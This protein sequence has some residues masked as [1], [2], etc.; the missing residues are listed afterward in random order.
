[1]IRVTLGPANLNN[2]NTFSFALV[3]GVH[4]VQKH[5]YLEETE[6]PIEEPAAAKGHGA[7]VDSEHPAHEHFVE[8]QHER[9]DGVGYGE[10]DEHDAHGHGAER[11]VEHHEDRQAV[12][13]ER[14]AWE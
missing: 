13:C 3:S 11:L 1:M 14:D 2:K 8:G 10:A 6:G 9:D 4:T 5:T 7:H 12:S